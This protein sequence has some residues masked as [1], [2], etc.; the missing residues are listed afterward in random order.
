MCVRLYPDII[1][2]T[3]IDSIRSFEGNPNS[4]FISIGNCLAH[5]RDYASFGIR[6]AFIGFEGAVWNKDD[7]TAYLRSLPQFFTLT[8]KGYRV[9]LAELEKKTVRQDKSYSQTVSDE[10]AGEKSS[11]GSACTASEFDGAHYSYGK[12][13][14]QGT[15]S[16]K[17]LSALGLTV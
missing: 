9:N 14:T 17:V 1:V 5:Q 13:L 16:P 3:E 10:T 4:I 6:N 8:D 12:L 2:A 15:Y 11:S 7:Y